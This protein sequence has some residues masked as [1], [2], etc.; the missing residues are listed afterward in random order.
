VPFV[1]SWSMLEAMS[2][3]C[4][5]VLSDTDPVREFADATMASLADLARPETIACAVLDTLRDGSRS[6][7][8]RMHARGA[9][10]ERLAESEQ[11]RRK[12]SL[13][14]SLLS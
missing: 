8:R 13:L 7:G 14:R 1:L 5:L 9:V 10:Q 3:A 11:F 12:E 2:C 6:A 4:A